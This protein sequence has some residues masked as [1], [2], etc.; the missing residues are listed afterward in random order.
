MD[1]VGLF[2]RFITMR[3][4]AFIMCVCGILIQPWR[5]LSQATTFVTVLSSFGG[6]KTPLLSLGAVIVLT[7]ALVFVGPIT[8]VIVCDFWV[9]RKQK[10]I[11]P[12]LFRQHGIYWYTAGLNW[13]AF[14]AF[15]LGFVWSMRKFWNLLN[16]CSY[17]LGTDYIFSWLCH[18]R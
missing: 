18:Y 15:T 3:R 2:P 9:V 16:S 10:W 4:G 5:F 11:V 13:R 14:A 6:N 7:L 17:G 12:D 1:L 8:G